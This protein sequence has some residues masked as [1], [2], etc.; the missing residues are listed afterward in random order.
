MSD[1]RV[2]SRVDSYL[3][4]M[5]L[6]WEKESIPVVMT[7]GQLMLQSIKKVESDNPIY[8]KLWTKPF[9]S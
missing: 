6:P 5:K 2:A 3:T 9:A 1:M 7:V 8:E 4:N